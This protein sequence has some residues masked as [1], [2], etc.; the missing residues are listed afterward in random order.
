MMVMRGATVTAEAAAAV[1]SVASR[2]MRFLVFHFVWG[3]GT[4][5]VFTSVVGCGIGKCSDGG[6]LIADA[7]V[8]ESDIIVATLMSSYKL[9]IQRIKANCS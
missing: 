7:V 5:E 6:F 1:A 2:G 8:W 3:A 4:C 9:Y